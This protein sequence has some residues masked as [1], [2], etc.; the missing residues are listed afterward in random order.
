MASR[1][2]PSTWWLATSKPPSRSILLTEDRLSLD[3]TSKLV[4]KP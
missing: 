1:M 4:G 3:Q 2:N